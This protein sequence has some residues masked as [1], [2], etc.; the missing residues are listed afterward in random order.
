MNASEFRRLWDELTPI[1]RTPGGGYRRF[2]WS[3][4][5]QACRNWFRTQAERRGMS[6]ETGRNGNLY[7]WWGSWHDGD[8][9]LTGS[10]FDSVPGGGAYDGP[11]GI[12]SAFL[13]IDLLRER[14]A[15]P[16]HPIGVAAFVEE[17]GGRFGIPCL[18]TRLLTGAVE[19]EQAR[20]LTD[21]DGVTFAAAMEASG[22]D[23][24]LLG[25]DLARIESLAAFIELH[26][27]QGRALDAEN[28][29]VGVA[30]AIW[31]HGRW[32]F[33]FTGESD[34]AG[35]TR[36]PDRRDPML[37]FAF[38]VLAARKEARLAGGVATVGR[39]EIDPGA[40]NVIPRRV[41]AWLDARAPDEAVLGEIVD[42]IESK[43][44]ERAERDGT[45]VAV[46][47]ESQTPTVE[48]DAGLRDRIARLLG[49]VPIVPTA[50]GHDA[51][52]LAAHVPTAMLFVRNPTGVSHAAAETASDDDCAA[53]VE[54]LADVLGELAC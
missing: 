30:S 50:A 40:T 12:A 24:S 51:A 17:E 36:L 8:A 18:G 48:F 26:I 28:A 49:G 29:P 33:T 16:R 9:V 54:A 35:T 32:R 6:V 31:P 4:A 19:P 5:D 53:G 14:G 27:E 25:P 13:A 41:D 22:A 39:A 46:T 45:S 21:A 52:V 38:T 2:S 44:A 34:H 7:A 15:E 42:A 11:L 43:T 47:A 23:P 10:H 1:G 20:K 37:T 3:D